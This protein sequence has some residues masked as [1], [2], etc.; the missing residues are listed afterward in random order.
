MQ[1]LHLGAH[2]GVVPVDGRT[3]HWGERS[4]TTNRPKPHF[5]PKTWC[6][7]TEEQGFAGSEA[8]RSTGRSPI[9]SRRRGARRRKNKAL[10]GAKH[11]VQ[12][13]EAPFCPED[14]VPDDGRTRHLGERSTTFNRPKP[15]FVPKPWCPS[16]KEQG[17][18]GSE[19]P[20]SACGRQPN[21]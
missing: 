20:Q 14:V 7:S 11:H 15:Y 13:A 1:V 4:T 17:I 12:P 6:P 5:V 8:P 10:R 2:V 9:L 18:A 19:A 16:T 21:R 3:R